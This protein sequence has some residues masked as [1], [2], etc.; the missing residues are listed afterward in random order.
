MKALFRPY[1]LALVAVVL[2]FAGGAVYLAGGFGAAEKHATAYF[3]KTTGLYVGDDVRVRGVTVGKVDAITP[4]GNQVKV[5]LH[6]EADRKLPADA[7]AA[8]VAPSLV[9]GRYLQLA[10]AHAD[11]AVLADGAVIPRERTAI[12]VEWDQISGELTR[13]SQA[14]GPQ[15]ANKQG[16]LGKSITSAADAF[17]GNGQQLHDTMAAMSQA[18]HGLSQDSGNLFSTV[19]DLNT[20]LQALNSSDAQV[21]TFSNQLA[22]ISSL[23]KDNRTQ[24]AT[25]LREADRAMGSITRFVNDNKSRLSTTVNGTADLAHLLADN[26]MKLANLL[27]LG[28]T[29]LANFYNSYDPHTGAFTGRLVLPYAKGLS[30]TVCQAI[31]SLGGTLQ[32]CQSALRPILDQLNLDNLPVSANPTTQPGTAN[33]KNPGEPDPKPQQPGG[34]LVPAPPVQGSRPG[35]GGLLGLLTGGGS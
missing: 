29:T 33:Q 30:N 15:G 21:T 31:Y 6:Y 4:Q 3:D 25:L 19:R 14:L 10:P 24:F 18:V 26:E 16:A 1:R 12:P 23:L 2:V 5:D 20:F 22:S 11:G 34:S 17:G 13:L 9:T 28:P 35:S 7:K 27:H 32:D 8:I